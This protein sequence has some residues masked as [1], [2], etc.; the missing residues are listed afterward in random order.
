MSIQRCKD[1]WLPDFE[2]G[3]RCFNEVVKL[4]QDDNAAGNMLWID[5]NEPLSTV[6]LDIIKLLKEESNEDLPTLS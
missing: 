2:K 5:C 6:W 1:D 4:A 3:F